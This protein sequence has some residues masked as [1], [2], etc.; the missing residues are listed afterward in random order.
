LAQPGF[1]GQLALGSL[2]IILAI[3]LLLKITIEFKKTHYK[4]VLG[5][6]VVLAILIV[7]YFIL[8]TQISQV[9][10]N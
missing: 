4:N 7:L 6:S 5:A 10:I 3:S 9:V 1:V 2:I 8:S